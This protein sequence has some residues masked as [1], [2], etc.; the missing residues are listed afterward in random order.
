VCTLMAKISAGLSRSRNHAN[1][2]L[3][4][5]VAVAVSGAALNLIVQ[6]ANYVFTQTG[7]PNTA[8]L[9]GL[10]WVSLGHR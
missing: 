8:G 9:Q 1:D 5:L 3:G 10:N 4:I 2:P 6:A 7:Q